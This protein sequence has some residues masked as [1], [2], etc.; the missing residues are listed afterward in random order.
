[1]AANGP[2]RAAAL[3][4]RQGQQLLRRQTDIQLRQARWRV[5]GGKA[6]WLAIGLAQIVGL[7]LVVKRHRI[8]AAIF[9]AAIHGHGGV[10]FPLFEWRAYFTMAPIFSS[11][12]SMS[13]ASLVSTVMTPPKPPL[14][15]RLVCAPL[16][17][18]ICLINSG[19]MKMEPWRYF[20]KP[21]GAVE[22]DLHV[23]HLVEAPDIEALA[24]GTGRAGQVHAGQGVEQ[25]ATLSA[26]WRSM[27]ALLI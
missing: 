8:E 18:S 21:L 22:D 4:R 27:S 2:S 14:P 3:H 9:R 20:S 1:M 26:C 17:T 7:A 24:A 6:E 15:Y 19:S 5:D 16:F 23:L 12:S 25:E 10:V 13:F 11:P